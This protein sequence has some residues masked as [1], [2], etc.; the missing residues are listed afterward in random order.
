MG[1]ETSVAMEPPAAS[2]KPKLTQVEGGRNA[3]YVTSKKPDYATTFRLQLEPSATSWLDPLSRAL[4][5]SETKAAKMKRLLVGGSFHWLQLR[6]LATSVLIL[7]RRLATCNTK[8]VCRARPTAAHT[9]NKH[10]S[11]HKLVISNEWPQF[12]TWQ[13]ISLS[14]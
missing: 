9:Q 12:E 13:I 8:K 7:T 5:K 10:T 2:C 14:K 3:H 6:A 1:P 4:V 11:K